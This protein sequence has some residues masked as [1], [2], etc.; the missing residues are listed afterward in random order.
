MRGT[1]PQPGSVPD[2]V[3]GFAVLATF[4]M[5]LTSNL[6]GVP[7]SGA[8]VSASP[9]ARPLMLVAGACLLVPAVVVG[10]RVAPRSA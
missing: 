5:T 7:T 8:E 1:N 6:L 10:R 9:T 4:L 3:M 2:R